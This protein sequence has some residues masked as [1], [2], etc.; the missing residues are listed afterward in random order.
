MSRARSTTLLAGLLLAALPAPIALAQAA[1]SGV[2]FEDGDLPA[3]TK[4]Q[5]ARYGEGVRTWAM[6]QRVVEAVAEQNADPPSE[7]RVREDQERWLA[8]E[9]RGRLVNQLEAN[10]CSEALDALM[11]ANPGYSLAFVTDRRGVVVCMSDPPPG[12]VFDGLALWRSVVLEGA[13]AFVGAPEHDTTSGLE[14]IWISVPVQQGGEVIGALTVG[15]LLAAAP[16]P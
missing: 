8:G 6:V 5:L 9:P 10:D 11:T 4:S 12:Y 15:K 1:V 7:E 2:V 14:R 16:T 13:S 3:R